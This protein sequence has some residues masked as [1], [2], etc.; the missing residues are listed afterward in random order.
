[1]LFYSRIFKVFIWHSFIFHWKSKNDYYSFAQFSVIGHWLK[2]KT[3]EAKNVN[4]F[5]IKSTFNFHHTITLLSVYRVVFPPCLN[6]IFLVM[7]MSQAHLPAYHIYS[8]CLSSAVTA[9]WFLILCHVKPKTS[10]RSTVLQLECERRAW[11]GGNRK[12]NYRLLKLIWKLS[13]VL[14]HRLS[15]VGVTVQKQ[16]CTIQGFIDSHQHCWSRCIC[17]SF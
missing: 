10:F 11:Q 6:L 16:L 9:C 3:W 15:F 4:V 2:R 1:M 7:H 14:I 12:M 5:V 8:L 13:N 17:L